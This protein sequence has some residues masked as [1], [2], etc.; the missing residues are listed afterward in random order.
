[1]KS[2]KKYFSGVISELK[3]VSWPSRA[4]VINHTLIV[5]ISSVVAIAVVAAIDYSLSQSIQYFISLK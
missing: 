1:M 4:T 2:I 5:L 3:K